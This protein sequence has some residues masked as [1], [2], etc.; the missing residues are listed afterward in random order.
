MSQLV[1]QTKKQ[2]EINNKQYQYYRLSELAGEKVIQRLPYSIR[3][4]LESLLRNYDGYEIKEESIQA[5][6]HWGKVAAAGVPFKPTRV[7]LQDLTG[8]PAVV[9]LA[10]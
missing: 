10:S 4:L 3:I 7:I 5:L 2:F 9:D 6:L 8:V 1:N